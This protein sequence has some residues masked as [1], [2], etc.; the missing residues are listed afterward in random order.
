MKVSAFKVEI[1][2]MYHIPVAMQ[3]LFKGMQRLE[4]FFFFFF[5]MTLATFVLPKK[6]IVQSKKKKTFFKL[7]SEFVCVCHSCVLWIGNNGNLIT[8]VGQCCVLNACCD[9]MCVLQV[10]MF[11]FARNL[12][13]FFFINTRKSR[14]HTHTRAGLPSN[15]SINTHFIFWLENKKGQ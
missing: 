15:T 14:T 13:L 3:T 5:L 10:F 1:Q 8:F 9:T 7:R 2:K 6:K 11:L 4:V 12:F